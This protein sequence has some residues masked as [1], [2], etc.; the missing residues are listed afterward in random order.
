MT[1]GIFCQENL[2]VILHW[3]FFGTSKRKCNNIFLIFSQSNLFWWCIFCIDDTDKLIEDTSIKKL[4][5]SIHY[6]CWKINFSSLAFRGPENLQKLIRTKHVSKYLPFCLAYFSSI[7]NWTL[8][9][10][11]HLMLSY[12]NFLT[13]NWH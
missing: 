7:W 8:L 2:R 9:I 5:I 11:R 6:K 13:S 10:I 4:K 1:F 12:I 3:Q